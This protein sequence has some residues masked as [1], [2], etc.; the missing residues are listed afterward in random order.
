MASRRP[1]YLYLPRQA[2]DKSVRVEAENGDKSNYWCRIN[3]L[4]F[5]LA[6]PFTAGDGISPRLYRRPLQGPSFAP[7]P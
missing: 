2:G 5:S 1:A 3:R 4:R 7:V 6:Q